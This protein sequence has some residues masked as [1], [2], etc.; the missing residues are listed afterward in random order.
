MYGNES[1]RK[2]RQGVYL[3]LLAV[4]HRAGLNMTKKFMFQT[5]REFVVKQ[6]DSK[7]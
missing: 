1:D 7:K 5:E 4:H 6:G 3:V 2:Q